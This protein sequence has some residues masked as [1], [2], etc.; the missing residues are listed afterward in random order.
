MVSPTKDH[1]QGIRW[2]AFGNE[3][4]QERGTVARILK[5]NVSDEIGVEE[6]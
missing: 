4:K 5:E 3:T 2:A 1:K 6:L